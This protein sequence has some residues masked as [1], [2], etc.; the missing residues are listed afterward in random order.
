[1]W[2][3]HYGALVRKLDDHYEVV[4]EGVKM[5][6]YGNIKKALGY[7]TRSDPWVLW[8]ERHIVGG[9]NSFLI[10]VLN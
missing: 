8:H 9:G 10:E 5:K 4:F 3:E 6:V 1:M 7:I 2:K